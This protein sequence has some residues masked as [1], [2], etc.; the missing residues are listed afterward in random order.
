MF[1]LGRVKVGSFLLPGVFF[2]SPKRLGGQNRP[3]SPKF[4]AKISSSGRP[5]CFSAIPRCARARAGI[6]PPGSF[7]G[8]PSRISGAGS[9]SKGRQREGK[10]GQGW[11]EIPGAAAPGCGIR[12]QRGRPARPGG[13]QAFKEGDPRLSLPKI[14]VFPCFPC[15]PHP[16]SSRDLPPDPKSALFFYSLPT[17]KGGKWIP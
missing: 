1:V 9:G 11:A 3:E 6:S 10:R 16:A 2:A 13:A 7:P 12:G 8:F 15:D 17:Q 4:P 5:R 14:P